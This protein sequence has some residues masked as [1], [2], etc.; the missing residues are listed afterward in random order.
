MDNNGDS[1]EEQKL[2][3]DALRVIK[4]EKHVSASLVSRRLDI[5]YAHSARLIDKLKESGVLNNKKSRFKRFFS[6]TAFWSSFIW[7]A[8]VVGVVGSLAIATKLGVHD[9]EFSDGGADSLYLFTM[10]SSF[11][12][13][14]LA[15][16]IMCLSLIGVFITRKGFGYLPPFGLR[17]RHMIIG[18]VFVLFGAFS[19]LFGMIQNARI[20]RNVI[21]ST[22]SGQDLFDG[23]NSYRI[24]QNIEPVELDPALCNNLVQ[25]YLDIT[26][27]LNEYV[28]HAGFDE[29]IK[30]ERLEN[31]Y[32]LAEIYITGS[33]SVDNAIRG[34]ESSPGHRLALTG[35]YSY[36]CTYAANG[37]AIAIFGNRL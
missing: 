12:L 24:A 22:Y 7:F 21:S 9:P 2:L 3:D 20:E 11:F 26:N 27:P 5:G 17:V 14:G 25:R 31:S 1:K 4:R 10:L 29:W 36:V 8:C 13:G 6:F 30:K 34:W 33:E 23:I 16:F 15:F 28:G 35:N 32:D 37:V 19:F 18:V